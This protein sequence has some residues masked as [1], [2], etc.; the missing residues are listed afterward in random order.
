M[1]TIIA[2]ASP[3]ALIFDV[4]FADIAAALAAAAPDIA[5]FMSFGQGT[6]SWADDMAKEASRYPDRGPAI[7][8]DSADPLLML[9]TAGSTGRPKGVPLK[10]TN[11]FFSATNWIIDLGIGKSDYTL[12]VLPLF[13]IGGH[14]LWTL[15]HLMIGSKVLLLRRFEPERTL[16]L[17]AKER[18]TNTYLIPA[19]AKMV[20]A[21]PD[22]R[23]YDL[24]SLRFIGSGGEAVSESITS[25]F[26]QIGIPVLNSYGLTETSDGTTSIRPYDAAGK[27]ANCIGQPLPFVDVKI[28]NA[29]GREVAP[30]EAGE[31]THRGPSVV[32]AY[33]RRPEETVKAFRDGWFYTGDI[34]TRDERGYIYFLA[35]KDDMIMSGGENV[36]PAEVEQAILG[37]PRIADAAVLGV[38][39]EKWGQ[40][41][42]AIVAPRVGECISAEDIIEYLENKLSSFKRP[43]VYEIVDQL[44]KLGS[45]KL[46]R[47]QIKRDYGKG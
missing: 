34:A 45:G 15:P 29:E 28:V 21:L 24:G 41:I 23:G 38:P 33:W 20:L 44:P 46:D 43:R 19:M 31:I 11:L 36:Y 32:D 8:G 5:T 7:T 47:A 35:R 39:D 17:I 4:E 22:W 26:G 9:Y 16:Q 10:Q 14:I 25:A 3:K 12:S 42:K 2:D 1:S 27:A 37:H 30:G 18:I 6:L 13:H 40:R